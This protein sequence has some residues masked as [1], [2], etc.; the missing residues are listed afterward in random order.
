MDSLEAWLPLLLVPALLLAVFTQLFLQV[1]LARAGSRKT[2]MSGYAVARHILDGAG[3]YDVQVQQV[4]GSLSDHFD[5]HRKVLQLSGEVF[6]GRNLAA[7]AVASHEACHALQH[8]RGNRLLIMREVAIPAASFGSGGGILIAVAGLVGRF[9]PLLAL[10]IILFSAAL[11]LQLLSLP[12]EI[13]A[14]ALARR[15]LV[16]LGIVDTGQL[17]GLRWSLAA[18]ALT[19]VGATLQSV[20]TLAQR[21]ASRAGQRRNNPP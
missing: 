4:P 15:R 11:Y 3:L 17:S 7:T 6:H 12:C 2:K 10:G 18:V 20:L 1:V 13:H 14:S 8:A 16:D 19:Y 9:P 21:F 5:S